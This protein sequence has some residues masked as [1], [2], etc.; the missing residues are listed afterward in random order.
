MNAYSPPSDDYADAEGLLICGKCNTRKQKIISLPAFEGL[1]VRGGIVG[2]TCDC[3]RAAIEAQ[4]LAD[5][6]TE[7]LRQVGQLRRDGLA[8]PTYSAANFEADDRRN[9]T[10]SSICR[11]Y[12]ANWEEM[13]KNGIGILFYG[14][15]GTGK[16]FLACAIANALL[17]KL[18]PTCVISFPRLLGQLE[19]FGADRLAFLD[20]LKR[21]QL[22]V[23]DDLGAE[24]STPFA[25]EQAFAVIDDRSRSGLPFIATTNLSMEDLQRPA[26]I[27]LARI[28][29]RILALCPIAVKLSGESRRP[30]QASTRRETARKLLGL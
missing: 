8:D 27:E 30:S 25:A 1:A 21:F 13:R 9:P 24:R 6:R 17:Q 4:Q 29:D 16:S 18:V 22:L 11:K 28:Y 23:V 26:S 15:V 14:G 19:A 5:E 7:F 10:A 2:I 12:V 20:K 3:E